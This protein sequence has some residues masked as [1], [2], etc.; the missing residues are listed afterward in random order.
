MLQEGA[1]ID[2][3][4][5]GHQHRVIADIVNGVPVVHPGYR[6][7]HIGEIQL[8]V[9]KIEGKVVV[10][11]SQAGVHSLEDVD[12]DPKILAAV[13][14]EETD[15]DDWRDELKVTWRLTIRWK[16]V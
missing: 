8:T 13:E 11:D 14:T 6:G 9:E 4:F 12:A 16:R 3:L 7:N 5:T 2:A 1:G 15:L 10:T